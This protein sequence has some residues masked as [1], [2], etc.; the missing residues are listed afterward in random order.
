M[1]K[2]RKHNTKIKQKTTNI[3]NDANTSKHKC[4][5]RFFLQETKQ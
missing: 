3:K 2:H 1:T 4:E 5:N